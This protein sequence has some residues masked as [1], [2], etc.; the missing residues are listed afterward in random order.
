MVSPT[1]TAQRPKM[2]ASLVPR[3]RAAEAVQRH[4]PGSAG[5]GSVM[6]CWPVALAH[7]DDLDGLL[8]ALSERLP[9]GKI[10]GE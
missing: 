7:W 5:N 6:R 1:A 4:K 10:M 3:E 8:R 9:A 2:A